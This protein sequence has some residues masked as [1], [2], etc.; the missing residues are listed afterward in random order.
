MS[1]SIFDPDPWATIQSR[2]QPIGQPGPAQLKVRRQYYI[3]KDTLGNGLN[4]TYADGAYKNLQVAPG[5]Y[6]SS[7]YEIC[8]Y[9]DQCGIDRVHYIQDLPL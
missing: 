6:V 7:D 8:R 9:L 1:Y 5:F 3:D 4:C 2:Q